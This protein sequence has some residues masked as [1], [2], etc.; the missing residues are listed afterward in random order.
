M[1]NYE[2]LG[3]RPIINTFATVTKYG[4][5]LMPDE[6]VQAMVDASKS[7]VDLAE[8]QRTVGERIAQATHN[9]AAYITSGAAAGVMLAAASCVVLKNPDVLPNFP[10]LASG[11]E[12]I[13][14]KSHRNGYDYGI[15]LA[16]FTIVEIPSTADA[17]QNAITANTSSIFWFQGAMTSADDLPLKQVI[18]IADSHEIPVIVDAAAQL[19][20]MENLWHF[21]QLGASLALFS[22]GK[23]LRGPQSSGLILGRRDLIEIIRKMSNP[24]QGIGR[25]AKVGKEELMG[26]LIA[27]ERYLT[28]DHE[29]RSQYC[30]DT[31]ILWCDALNQLKGVS[32]KRDYPNEAGQP[33]P[34]CLV[35]I[36]SDTLGKN[37]DV[38]IEEFL[39]A[40]PAIAVAPYNQGQFHLNPMTLN[41]G[42]EQIVLKTSLEILTAR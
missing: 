36:D 23:D 5:S 20:P 29:A 6:V 9:E 27:V 13:I 35:T 41:E 4:G 32:A 39:N 38:I 28:L 30:E 15:S 14:F 19:P 24:N 3:I 22:G 11:Q 33:L 18:D 37:C 2:S 16:G 17:L 31:V 12:V 1:T 34:W 26:I 8:L 25:V 40:T 21:T 42:E 7:F 10:Q